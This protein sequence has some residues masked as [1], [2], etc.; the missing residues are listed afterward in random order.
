MSDPH[1]PA[2][3]PFDD[4]TPTTPGGRRGRGVGK[5]LLIGCGVIL[6]LLAIALGTLIVFQDSIA[7]WV[8]EALEAQVEPRLPEDLPD[9]VR[10]RYEAAFDRAIAAAE[11]GDYEP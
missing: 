7:A 9:D 3:S 11:E 4:S 10:A 1:A 2:P 8:F 5:P 6:V